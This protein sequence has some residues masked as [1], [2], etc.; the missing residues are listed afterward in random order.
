LCDEKTVLEI[1]NFKGVAIGG[2]SYSSFSSML[3][4]LFR[5]W[6]DSCKHVMRDVYGPIVGAV[7]EHVPV[8]EGSEKGPS[9]LLPGAGLC[10]LGYE[11]MC[12]GYDVECNE[13]SKVFVT[14]SDF[15]F[16]GCSQQLP[17]APLAH[18]FTENRKLSDQ[19]F[20][21]DVPTPMP[22]TTALEKDR[23]MRMTA[24][25]VVSI[26]KA[27]G[28][29]HRKFDGVVTCFFIDTGDDLIEYMRT[30]DQVLDEGGVWINYGPLNFKKDLRLKLTWE[31]IQEVWEHMGYEFLQVEQV[32]TS[33]N[34]EAG[35]K[36]YTERYD[37]MFTVARKLPKKAL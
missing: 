2:E 26:Y 25:D 32:H 18:S 8:R 23:T 15:I 6:S 7:K 19:Y 21:V 4:H 34:I 20:E 28:P 5:D 22:R 30:I 11:L 10:R 3:L 16:N 24:G 27:G 12:E 14:L 13:F 17:I 1:V 9:L 31:E 33:Y 37:P 35:I 36:L 29:G